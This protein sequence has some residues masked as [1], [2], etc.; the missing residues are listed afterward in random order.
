MNRVPLRRRSSSR[1]TLRAPLALLLLATFTPLGLPAANPPAPSAANPA[2]E[3]APPR[4]GGPRLDVAA[5]AHDFGRIPQGQ[6]AHHGFKITNT[7]DALLEITEV[8]PACGCTTAGDWPHRLP[9]GE[10]GT[11]SIQME[12]AQ[13]T[14]P[15]AKTIT[16]TSN[17]P[18]HPQTVLEIK[19]AVWTPI[20]ISQPVVIFPALTEPTQVLTRSVTI[21]NQVE[22]VLRL[23]ELQSDQPAFQPALKEIVPGREF[24]LTVTTVPPLAN[25]TTTAHIT[26]KT[27]NPKMPA[28][29]V[30]A[31]ATLLPPVQVAPTEIMLPTAKLLTLEKRYVVLLNHRGFD[32]QLSEVKT[33]AAGVEITTSITQD[34][35]QFTVLL[36]FP[37]GFQAD[38]PGKRSVTGQTNH[39]ELPTF[40]VPIVYT[41]NR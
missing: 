9:P 19:A 33:N 10:T 3:I 31:V 32:L 34:K 39:P 26:L 22:G 4:N 14:G 18:T 15:I 20:Q 5:P 35:K 29:T 27:S 12:T 21:R 37:A 38:A 8:K 24:E 41:G 25:G 30:Q 13:F 7:G 16:V 23:S 1:R 2:A 40:E 36:T 11:I 28:L 17:D 6:V